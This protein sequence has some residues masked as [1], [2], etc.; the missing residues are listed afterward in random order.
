[1]EKT[2]LQVLDKIDAPVDLQNIEAC[3]R[4]KSDDN[5]RSN[6]VIV[7]SSKRK[8]MVRVM[9]KKKSLKN[10][11]L[12]VSPLVFAVTRSICGINVKHYGQV[13]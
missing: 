6:K 3:D 11:N 7:K 10:V 1:M 9:K 4:L 12:Q 8:D 13:N 5:G 2:V